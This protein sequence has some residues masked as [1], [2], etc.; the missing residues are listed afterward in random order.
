MKLFCFKKLSLALMA[1]VTMLSM[2]GC[3]STIVGAVVDT[4]IEVAKVPFKVGGAIVDMATSDKDDKAK[5]DKKE[6]PKP[7]E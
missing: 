2:Q 4:T 6:A 3:I 1:M 7:A 5:K